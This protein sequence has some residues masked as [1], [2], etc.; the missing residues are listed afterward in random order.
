MV[1]RP[2]PLL[3]P[4]RPPLARRLPTS[5]PRSRRAPAGAGVEDGGHPRVSSVRVGVSSWSL[6]V[7]RPA[8]TGRGASLDSQW[9]PECLL[10]ANPG[11]RVRRI[12]G[13]CFSVRR[14]VFERRLRTRPRREMSQ[15]MKQQERERQ[16]ESGTTARWH[17]GRCESRTIRNRPYPV[18]KCSIGE[19]LRTE[20]GRGRR[21]RV[22]DG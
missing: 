22:G 10:L 8:V 17:E 19:K 21:P 12:C 7:R 6:A 13:Q 3:P 18:L 14:G 9:I 1:P 2:L 5:P 15:R 4:P 20:I 11:A 16:D